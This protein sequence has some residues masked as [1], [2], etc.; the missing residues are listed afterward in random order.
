MLV[1]IVV[2]VGWMRVDSMMVAYL[3]N[4]VDGSIIVGAAVDG[5]AWM[6]DA[7]MMR[8]V[9]MVSRL[10]ATMDHRKARS[11]ELVRVA[12][13]GDDGVVVVVVIVVVVVVVVIGEG[14][15]DETR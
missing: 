9:R 7:W 8:S 1:V 14:W 13:D 5:C 15:I 12:I 2:V 3:C 6:A 11:S 4:G 10:D